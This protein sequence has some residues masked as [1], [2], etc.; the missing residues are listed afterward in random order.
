M[1]RAPLW[2]ATAAVVVLA[3]CEQKP[4]GLDERCIVCS[5][6]S[7]RYLQSG[8]GGTTELPCEEGLYCNDSTG[9]CAAFV[10]LG[11]E[12]NDDTD[13]LC[14]PSLVCFNLLCTERI[15]DGA[16]CAA[17]SPPC[18]PTSHCNGGGAP[19]D[20]RAG[21]CAPSAGDA[22]APCAWFGSG[23]GFS[24]QG[25]ADALAC[26]PD[27]GFDVAAARAAH[28]T[29]NPCP[30]DLEDTALGDNGCLGWPGHCAV[31]GALERGA[32]CVDDRSCAS[33]QCVWLPPPRVET[34]NNAPPLHAPWPGVCAG[35]DDDVPGG[36][37]LD[38]LPGCGVPCAAHGD[39]FTGTVCD[40]GTCVAAL[41]RDVGDEC[42][43]PTTPPDD[44]FCGAGLACHLDE[45]GYGTCR[46]EG[47]GEDGALCDAHD[48]CAGGHRCELG[49]CRSEGE[50][51]ET[52]D[53]DRRCGPGLH[54]SYSTETCVAPGPLG[55]GADCTDDESCGANLVCSVETG[56]CEGRAFF[57][58]FCSS[59]DFDGDGAPDTT[60]R[61]DVGLV[62]VVDEQ[63]GFGACART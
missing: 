28:L 50:L 20:P 63:T 51:G 25:C 3:A 48:D 34:G 37:C 27:V 5:A 10:G 38:R 59:P 44:A 60:S 14:D 58:S 29:P 19:D 43:A 45:Y 26:V 8:C 41:T 21:I 46:L 35:P 23:Q 9:S 1:S 6:G 16:P 61:C 40:H 55:Q 53:F 33:G 30:L 17:G 12:C 57:G 32:P 36:V 24:A 39:C 2:L 56:R 31:V 42:G 7:G 22:G 13:Y 4:L 52:C 47:P 15:A 54:C 49:V 18:A 11:A 62:C